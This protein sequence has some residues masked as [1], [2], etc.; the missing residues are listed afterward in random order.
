MSL[1]FATSPTL[2]DLAGT[3]APSLF[4]GLEPE[5]RALRDTVGLSH[6]AHIACSRLSG[7]G[8]WEV[9]DRVCPADLYLRDLQIRHTLLLDDG[10]LPLADLYVGNDDDGFILLADGIS[11]PAL[12]AHIREHA[13]AGA[14]FTL[15]DLG[16]THTILSLNGPF[17]WEALAAL[18]GPDIIGF[19]YL[20]FYH[21]RPGAT[22]FRAGKTGEYG[23]DLLVPREQAPA[24]WARLLDIG[25]RLGLLEVG[26]DALAHAQLENWFFDMHREG[27]AGLSPIELQLQWRL[28]TEDKDYVGR[29]ALRQRPVTGRITALRAAQPLVPGELVSYRD[30]RIGVVIRGERSV[31]LGDEIGI[32]LIDRSF[33]HSGIDVFRIGDVPVRTV[34]PPFVN[35]LSLYVNPQQHTWATRHEV[36]FPGAERRRLGR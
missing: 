1:P 29:A 32:A 3:P 14:A 17:A 20:T 13:P 11:G 22:Y 36:A 10:G 12:D 7:A 8:M 21:P 25:G 18:E 35:N 23:Y 27:R 34:S 6:L 4:T 15:T 9:L 30:E 33:A 19:P 16:V 28:A 5:V 24:L 2:R 26:L 31:T